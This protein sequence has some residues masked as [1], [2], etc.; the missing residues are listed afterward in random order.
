MDRGGKGGATSEKEKSPQVG[1]S[2]DAA[3]VTTTAGVSSDDFPLGTLLEV[4]A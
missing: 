1:S 4:R 2:K 3:N